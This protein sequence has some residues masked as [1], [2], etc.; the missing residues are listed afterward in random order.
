MPGAVE[1]SLEGTIIRNR[2][3]RFAEHC[4]EAARKTAEE[5]SEVGARVA[6][7][8][9]PKRTGAM[10]STIRTASFAYTVGG[11]TVGTDHWDYQEFGTH[12]H[13]ITGEVSF[14]WERESRPWTPGRNVIHHPGNRAVHF[15]LD[16]Y[17]A[18]KVELIAAMYRNY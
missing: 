3:G 2:F 17:E 5:A 14:F 4:R 18:S 15:M 9:A 13:E 7:A 8:R 1:V 11:F 16:G 6:R 12:P 10:A